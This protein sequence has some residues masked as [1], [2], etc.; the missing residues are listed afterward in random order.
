MYC[1]FKQMYLKCLNEANLKLMAKVILKSWCKIVL[2]GFEHFGALFFCIVVFVLCLK[3]WH[4]KIL[5]GCQT[6]EKKF[7]KRREGE[8]EIKTENKGNNK[9]WQQN[10]LDQFPTPF[11]FPSSP[12]RIKKKSETPHC[13]TLTASIGCLTV[14]HTYALRWWQH[15]QHLWYFLN[16]LGDVLKQSSG[17]RSKESFNLKW[18]PYG[19]YY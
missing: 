17:T 15:N 3:L 10:L 13:S 12:L 14:M 5:S 18:Y 16:W 19:H 7:E 9:T 4:H 6:K 2:L 8:K 1:T 11:K